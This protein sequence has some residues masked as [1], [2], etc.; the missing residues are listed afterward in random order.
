MLA[1]MTDYGGPMMGLTIR[2][3]TEYTRPNSIFQMAVVGNVEGVRA[4][5]DKRVA[6]PND[7]NTDYGETPLWV[8]IKIPASRELSE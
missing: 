1:A 4:L 3:R 2:R 8:S 5:L 6:S 7:V